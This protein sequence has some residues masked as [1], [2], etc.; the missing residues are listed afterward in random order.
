MTVVIDGEL[1]ARVDRSSP[2]YR[3]LVSANARLK[4]KDPFIWGESAALEAATRL[5]WVDLPTTSLN[6]IPQL[7]EIEAKFGKGNQLILCG[8]GGSSLAPEVL[9]ATYGKKIFILDSTDPNYLSH[10]LRNNL[11][12]TIVL[13]SSK[14]GSTI[15]TSSQRSFFE[16]QFIAAGLDPKEHMIFCTDPD[17]PLDVDAK[18]NGFQVVNADP[19]VG[20]RFSALSAFG[21]VPAA[22][23]GIEINELLISARQTL[24]QLFEEFNPAIDLAYLIATQTEQYLAFTDSLTMPGLSDWIE[25]LIAESTGKEGTGRLPV[26][27]ETNHATIGSDQIRIG[28][29]N[30]GD[31]QVRGNLASQFIFWEWTTALL[32]AALKIDP[33]NQPNVTE[34]KEQTGRLLAEWNGVIPEFKSNAIDGEI[35]IFGEMDS[36]LDELRKIIESIPANGYLAITAYLDRVDDL[37]IYKLRE[38]LAKKSGRPVTFGWGPRF[39]HSTGQFHKGGQPNGSFLQLTGEVETDFGIPNQKYTFKALL[40]AQALGDARA[41]KE[42]NYPVSRLHFRDR[43]VAIAQLIELAK[44]L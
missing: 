10:A 11:K 32:G 1:L 44:K 20:G 5:N 36:A 9:A 37:E 23:L 25:Q 40:M 43:K 34:A 28:F 3:T 38:V 24:G 18:K 6:L 35:E 4:T 39:L 21:L 27:I 41:L 33:F 29:E 13:V 16:N 15:E 8:M 26:V 19:N 42:R 2:L 22:I 30:S 17:S 31:L 14:S 7:E 12:Q